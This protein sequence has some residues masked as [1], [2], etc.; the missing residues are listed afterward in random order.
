LENKN[1]RD[2]YIKDM[3]LSNTINKVIMEHSD[4]KK[5]MIQESKI[6]NN[7]FNF[8]IENYNLNRKSERK[9]AFIRTYQIYQKIHCH[10]KIMN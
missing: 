4:N 2:I 3:G 8:I 9:L 10:L 5:R 1:K 6:L 7:K